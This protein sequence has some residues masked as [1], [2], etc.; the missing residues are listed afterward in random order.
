MKLWPP[1]QGR[2]LGGHGL[3][4][5]HLS[6][7]ED[8]PRTSTPPWT[9]STRSSPTRGRGFSTCTGTAAA[10]VRVPG[11]SPST[12]SAITTSSSRSISGST[13][14]STTSI[15]PSAVASASTARSRST[16]PAGSFRDL[17]NRS[18]VAFQRH[19][20]VDKALVDLVETPID[21]LELLVDSG[22]RARQGFDPFPVLALRQH[23][24]RQ[25]DRA[26]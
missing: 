19:L 15:L 23:R 25:G 3:I 12:I 26:S 6:V 10:P 22:Q 18:Q 8:T 14:L 2:L 21:P 13:G 17:P 4:R 1:G 20:D 7:D 24:L 16:R 9:S 11:T 5:E